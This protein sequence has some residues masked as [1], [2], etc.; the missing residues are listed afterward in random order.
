MKP[1][2]SACLWIWRPFPRFWR[3]ENV[4]GVGLSVLLA[5]LVLVICSGDGD[6]EATVSAQPGG[7]QE[8][9]RGIDRARVPSTLTRRQVQILLL[10]LW[11]SHL[12][13]FLLS[14]V[15]RKFEEYK[16]AFWR[17]GV[18]CAQTHPWWG[19]T[20][21]EIK[22]PSA[23]NQDLPKVPRFKHGVGQ[24]GQTSKCFSSAAN[25]W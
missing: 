14:A 11:E 8:E 6:A 16:F 7:H 5:I 17:F 25:A 9:N 2:R 18:L 13:V 20:D 10:S 24:N 15:D 19:T 12:V 23:E 3:T 4:I 21:A 1:T 22:V